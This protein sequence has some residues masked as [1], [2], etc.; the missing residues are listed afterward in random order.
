MRA[1]FLLT[2]SLLL[3]TVIC[4]QAQSGGS[5]AQ[6]GAA[7]TNNARKAGNSQMV[8]KGVPYNKEARQQGKSGKKTD[9]R[10]IPKSSVDTGPDA[11]ALPS[12]N[13]RPNTHT[14]HREHDMNRKGS[15]NKSNES[16]PK[17]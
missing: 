13:K 1:T 8:G 5:A 6:Q 3:A 4:V 10:S 17:L 2:A 12:S 14:A 16:K 11:A 7:T 15:P 9:K